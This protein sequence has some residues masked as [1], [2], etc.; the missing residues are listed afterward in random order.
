M[1]TYHVYLDI[2]TDGPRGRGITTT[3][4]RIVTGDAKMALRLAL[5]R[6]DEDAKVAGYQ[7]WFVDP[8][9]GCECLRMTEGTGQAIIY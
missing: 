4:C 7:V 2:L 3:K 6:L 9:D 1:H 8:I 5:A